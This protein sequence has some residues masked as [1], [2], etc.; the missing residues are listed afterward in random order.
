MWLMLHSGTALLAVLFTL[1]WYPVSD[2]VLHLLAVY[3]CYKSMLLLELLA[4]HLDFLSSFFFNFSTHADL[5]RM[6]SLFCVEPI[7]S[8]PVMI[9]FSCHRRMYSF[10]ISKG[11]SCLFYTISD[12]KA[13]PISHISF[14]FPNSRITILF[15]KSH[16]GA[17]RTAFLLFKKTLHWSNY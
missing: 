17:Q 13:N 6:L 10:P 11:W 8:F 1:L 12:R 4:A 15:L 5:M 7:S 16:T 2:F 14:C 9:C 3:P